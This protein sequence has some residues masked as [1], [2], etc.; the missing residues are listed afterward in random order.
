[1]RSIA[2]LL[3]L[4][5]VFASSGQALASRPIHASIDVNV[6]ACDPDAGGGNGTAQVPSGTDFNIAWD[7]EAYTLR[8]EAEFLHSVKVAADV[9]GTSI[10]DARR[11]WT[12]PYYVADAE[13][14]W[15][16][17]WKYPHRALRAG[18]S[19]TFTVTPSL[20]RPVF[21][22]TDWYPRGPIVTLNCTIT[23]A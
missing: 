18:Q 15:F 7:W 13:Y 10:P 6:V 5:A 1:V 4:T 21:D 16:M 8:Q 2:T 14:P 19:I 23:G 3:A 9:D 17:F 11:Y 12:R 20:R 22:G